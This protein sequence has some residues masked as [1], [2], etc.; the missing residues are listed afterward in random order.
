MEKTL[1]KRNKK[2]NKKIVAKATKQVY[3]TNWLQKQLNTSNQE[4]E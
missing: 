1:P 2:D 3:D 4:F